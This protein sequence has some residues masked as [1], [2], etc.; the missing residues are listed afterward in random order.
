MKGSSRVYLLSEFTLPERVTK[1]MPKALFEVMRF[2]WEVDEVELI[3]SR[4]TIFNFLLRSLIPYEES[5][6]QDDSQLRDEL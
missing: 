3:L 4:P 6:H 2:A 1:V 5:F